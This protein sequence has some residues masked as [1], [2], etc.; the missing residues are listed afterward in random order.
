M[1]AHGLRFLG[2]FEMKSA[3]LITDEVAELM[4]SKEMSSIVGGYAPNSLKTAQFIAAANLADVLSGGT[5]GGPA[6]IGKYVLSGMSGFVV[7]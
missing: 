6:A 1:F 4:T 5:G 7:Q 3:H 2:D